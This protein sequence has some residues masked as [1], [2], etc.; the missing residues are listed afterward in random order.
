MTNHLY[1]SETMYLFLKAA[2]EGGHFRLSS[3][4]IVN[5]FFVSLLRVWF[6]ILI[7]LIS[8]LFQVLL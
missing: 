4:I 1:T 8:V 3:T 6:I 2:I 5:T 7:T